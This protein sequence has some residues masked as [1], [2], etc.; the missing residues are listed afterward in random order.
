MTPNEFREKLKES[1]AEAILEGIVLSDDA[2][3]VSE[4]E[5]KK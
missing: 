4:D 1:D 3:H 5:R 2:I